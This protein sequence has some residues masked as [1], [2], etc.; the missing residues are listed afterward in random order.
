MSIAMPVT[1]ININVYTASV[2]TY[3]VYKGSAI[4][5]FIQASYDCSIKGT[6]ISI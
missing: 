5:G 2:R 6:K 3:Y 1:I 4:N